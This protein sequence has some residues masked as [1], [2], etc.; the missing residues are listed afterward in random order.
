MRA[1]GEST[2][3]T[4]AAG[5]SSLVVVNSP[6]GGSPRATDD[7][8]DSKTTPHASGSPGAENARA[9]STGSGQRGG[10]ILEM[11]ESRDSSDESMTRASLSDDSTRGDGGGAP[12]HHHEQ[13]NSKDRDNTGASAHAG[14]NQ[15]ARDRIVLRHA[16]QVESPWMPSARELDRVAGMTTDPV[17]NPVIRLQEDLPT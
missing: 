12:I 10:I 11:F 7:A 14:T 2:S 3:H 1:T 5:I 8:S 4:T 9:R 17:S 15:E 16:P 6:R 13:S